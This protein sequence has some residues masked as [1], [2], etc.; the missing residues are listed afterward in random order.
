MMDCLISKRFCL[1]LII[2]VLI[3][4]WQFFILHLI[5]PVHYIER[6]IFF[7]DLINQP[8]HISLWLGY[9]FGFVDMVF[10]YVIGRKLFASNNAFIP[11]L[12]FG[13]SPW[14]AY[15]LAAG[16]VYP[17]VVCLILLIGYGFL[18]LDSSKQIFGK[19]LIIIGSVIAFYSSLYMIIV[20]PLFFIGIVLFKIIPLSRIALIILPISILLLP[21]AFLIILNFGGAK[22]IFNQ[23]VTIFYDPGVI[24]SINVFQGQAQKSGM[25]QISRIAENRYEHLLRYSILKIMGNLVPAVYFTPQEKLLGFS[26]S[27]PIYLGFII[28]FLYGL[29]QILC[30]RVLRKYFVVSLILII[31]SVMA[32][33]QVDLNRLF[34][35]IPTIV[36]T[37]SYGLI[38]LYHKRRQKLFGVILYS[39]LSL[40]IFQMV[41]TVFDITTREHQRYLKYYS[42]T[43]VEIGRQ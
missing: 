13:I 36:L 7:S 18:L 35:I 6:N 40:I 14:T 32:Q 39:V 3:I 21:L 29:Y 24:Q 5:F 12:I 9:L 15:L 17:F 1:Q 25:G 28:P 41:V 31:P 38:V 37:I 23:Q 22:N 43:N 34:I 2:L 8:I 30:S 11:A 27:P 33:Q 26:F 16:S 20:L 4:F 19:I 10:Y 42:I